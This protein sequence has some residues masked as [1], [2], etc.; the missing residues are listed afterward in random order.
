MHEQ[1]GVSV[2]M[3][4]SVYRRTN[5]WEMAPSFH[6][7]DPWGPPQVRLGGMCLYWSSHLGGPRLADPLSLSLSLSLSLCV[8][9]G[10]HGE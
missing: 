6:H 5:L 3:C 8:C 9:V 4:V 2:C 10:G 1:N 7:V